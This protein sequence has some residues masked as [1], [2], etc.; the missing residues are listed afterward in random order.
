MNDY[1]LIGKI[2]NTHGIKGEIRIISDFEL[3]EKVFK[4][5]STIYIGKE[6]EEA[7]IVSYREHKMFDMVLLEGK[8]DI[9][10][11]LKYKD[12]YVYIKR[13]SL[14][15]EDNEYLLEEIV[16]FEVVEDKDLLQKHYKSFEENGAVYYQHQSNKEAIGKIH[17]A[18]L[19]SERGWIE[20]VIEIFS[21]KAPKDVIE[22][23]NRA[24]KNI[25]IEDIPDD[26]RELFELT[27]PHISFDEPLNPASFPKIECGQKKSSRILF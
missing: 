6:K 25:D 15:L 11:V 20:L 26:I 21:D 23:I 9:D 27:Q 17:K 18:F 3:K 19:N 16:G 1:I 22:R 7:K 8:N 24:K 5:D 4:K 12:K 13:K 10:E 14:N 2:V